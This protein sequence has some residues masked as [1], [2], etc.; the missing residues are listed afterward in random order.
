[1][2]IRLTEGQYER[3]LTE[4]ENFGRLGD[5]IT[6][7]I[8]KIFKLLEK[9]YGKS[10]LLDKKNQVI[11]FL[12]LA[13]GFNRHESNIIFNTYYNKVVNGNL[14]NLLGQPLDFVA[15][16]KIYV[17]MPTIIHART[18]IPGF[19]A[20]EATSEEEALNKASDGKYIYM[21]LDENSRE[22]RY[23]DLD[24]DL[25]SDSKI[26]T[27]MVLDSIRDEWVLGVEIDKEGEY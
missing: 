25:G 16:Y 18:H 20:V 2:K 26:V 8:L 7:P 10:N 22:F 24:F 15:I 17:H 5:V 1:M 19:V 27:D 13:T 23:P 11:D 14:E 4:N 9:K 12:K 6:E 3:L 21:E